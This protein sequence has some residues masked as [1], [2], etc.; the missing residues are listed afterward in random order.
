MPG[1]CIHD[2]AGGHYDDERGDLSSDQ[3]PSFKSAQRCRA[4]LCTLPGATLCSS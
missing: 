2:V 4:N 1:S 3:V